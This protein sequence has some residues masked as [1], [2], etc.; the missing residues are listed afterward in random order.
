[1][2]KLAMRLPLGLWLGLLLCSSPALGA[3][4]GSV[5]GGRI[6]CHPE[7]GVQFCDGTVATRVES[8]DGV[9]LDVS[10]TLPPGDGSPPYPLIVQLHGWSLGKS[11]TPFSDDAKNGYAVL[12]YTARGFHESCGSAA[13]RAP[14]PGLGDPDV[15]AKRGWVHL[16]DARFEAHDTQY[17]AGLLADEGIVVPDRIGV[18]G[19][20]YGGGQ[21]L[22]LAALRDRV[23]LEDGRLVPWT[24][25]GGTPMRIAAAAPLIPWSDLAYA[26]EPNG[27]TLDY[28]ARNDYGERAGVQKQSWNA[29]LYAAGLG[30]GYYA[31]PGADPRADLTSWNARIDAGEPYD[32]DP[33]L[34]QVLAEITRFHSAYGIDDSVPPAPLFIYNAWTDD[35][36]PADEA[37]R[38]WRHIKSRFP[39]ADVAL[40]FADGFGHPR[41]ALGGNVAL[42]NARVSD[43]FALHLKD[44]AVA[45]PPRLE[46]YTQT[47]DGSAP[48]GPYVA[49]SWDQIHPGEVRFSTHAAKQFSSAGGD[50]ATAAALDPLAG[51]P[52][53]TVAA[54]DD[55][56]AATYRLPAAVGDGYTLL[57]S[58]TVI[59]DL[60]VRGSFAEV[61][62]RLW[63][64]SPDGSQTLISHSFYRP[65]TDD[66]PRQVFQL[67]PNGWHFAAGHV[68][69]LELLGQSAPFG[70]PSNGTFSVSAS[71]LELRLPVLEQPDGGAVLAPAAPIQPPGGR[72]PIDGQGRSCRLVPGLRGPASCR[73]LPILRRPS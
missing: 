73:P 59:A 12:S 36:F 19:A 39:D 57:G 1:L 47:C 58:P 54:S 3:A 16:A 64:V 15:C 14:D 11:T 2:A 13:S 56:G 37:L 4:V 43:F 72:E 8:F 33:Y 62:A 67:H 63:D 71:R 42:V 48:G 35:L 61:A 29:A 40:H 20:S 27:R 38:F 28:R 55:P 18:T 46:T 31:P 66:A 51:G 9:P 21:S 69:K 30:T 41:A 68:A 22:I 23:M 45:P 34:T 10:L 26:L 7:D 53:R 49:A 5:F 50:P 24:S 44:A 52:C 25:P 17:L 32:G 6:P 70:R 60:S 65:R